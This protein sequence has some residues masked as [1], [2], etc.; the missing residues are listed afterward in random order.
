TSL[1]EAYLVM[2]WIDGEDLGH[3]LARGRLPVEACVALGILNVPA[4]RVSGVGAVNI[5]ESTAS[6]RFDSLQ[7]E[8]HG[9]FSERFN[10]NLSYVFSNVKDDV[11]D[12]FDLAGAY[13]LPQDSS[14]LAAERGPANFDVRHR[15]TYDLVYAVPEM[16]SNA[17]LKAI[18]QG[19]KFGGSGT[20]HSGQP[21]TVNSIID[22]NLDGNLTD[23]LDSTSGIEVTGDRSQPVRLTGDPFTMLAPFGQNG[24]VGR[25]SFR[26]GSFMELDLT[27]IKTFSFGTARRLSLRADIFNFI[28]RA[29]FGVPVRLL[30]AVGFGRVTS[31]LTPGRRVQ[32]GVKFDF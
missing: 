16:K 4:R 1:D 26:A 15:W 6:S 23:R 18:T 19:L 25:N 13:S 17:V 7:S 30:E 27:V 14:D 28:D 20:Y 32:L 21:F 11:S 29:N 10:F 8:L 5:F 24:S 12:V 3:L 9:R 2:E 22:V 31:T